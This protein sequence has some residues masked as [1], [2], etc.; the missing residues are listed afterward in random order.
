MDPGRFGSGC[1][2]TPSARDPQER[3]LC[4]RRRTRLLKP[5]ARTSDPSGVDGDLGP[6]LDGVHHH[7]SAQNEGAG[8]DFSSIGGERLPDDGRGRAVGR[9]AEPQRPE[10]SQD[11]FEPGTDPERGDPSVPRELDSGPL[12]DVSDDDGGVSSVTVCNADGDGVGGHGEGLHYEAAA[13]EILKDAH[14]VTQLRLRVI[15]CDCMS[16]PAPELAKPHWVSR[17]LTEPWEVRDKGKRMLHFFDLAT[18]KVKKPV[19]SSKLFREE[20]GRLRELEEQ[21]NKLVETP[22]MQARAAL[23]APGQV[24]LPDWKTHRA[25][26]LMLF[27]QAQRARAREMQNDEALARLLLMEDDQLDL[28][29]GLFMQ[30]MKLVRLG[31][32]VPEYG[33]FYP[34]GGLFPFVTKDAGCVTGWA[35]GIAVPVTT[36]I[37]FA[38]VADTADTEWL[39]EQCGTT[40]HLQAFS[41]AGPKVSRVVIPPT[42]VNHARQV[43]GSLASY[44]TR[45]R[46]YVDQLQISREVHLK[47]LQ[48]GGMRLALRGKHGVGDGT[49]RYR[50]VDDTTPG[51]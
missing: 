10:R 29:V 11:R 47:Q 48:L 25:I 20:R 23:L 24:E 34:D 7:F 36:S 50:V 28:I 9:G 49:Q 30:D 39:F 43:S 17:C 1:E 13:K 26:A 21:L 51:V 31:N 16:T 35:W 27:I 6:G 46:E 4:R 19:S 42:L 14:G 45:M 32:S 5:T 40:H 2:I 37:A 33:L 15:I 44:R 38:Y 22:I 18:E 12:G 8:E 3:K 41:L